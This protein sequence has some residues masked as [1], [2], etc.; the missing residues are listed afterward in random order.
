MIARVIPEAYDA[1]GR[2][3]LRPL[4]NRR[5]L[6]PTFP[7][8]RYVSQPLS[9]SCNS[10][11]EV[12]DFLAKCKAVSDQDQFGKRDYWLPPDEFERTKQGDCEDFSFWT[13]RQL[14]AMGYD[15]R[16]VFGRHGRYGT[17]HA[18]VHF[19]RNGDCFLVE[20]QYWRV[21]DTFPTLS[22]SF[23]HPKFSIAWD[24]K[25]ITYFAHEDRPFRPSP[26]A[27]TRLIADWFCVWAKFW[28]RSIP[29]LPKLCWFLTTKLLRGFKSER[30][31]K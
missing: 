31:T 11:Q 22:T 7:I 27:L 8:G 29:R 18:W 17:G 2:R 10:I 15:A 4:G 24:G 1:V 9:I 21:G 3:V 14:M 16:V 13:W 28:V 25:V 30:W 23:Y 5:G 6:H 12:R 20:P 26:L 19:F